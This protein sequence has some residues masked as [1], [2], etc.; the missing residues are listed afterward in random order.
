MSLV[1]AK[2][3]KFCSRIYLLMVDW[4]KMNSVLLVES[5][6]ESRMRPTGLDTRGTLLYKRFGF[7]W[8]F[9]LRR[10][11]QVAMKGDEAASGFQIAG[12]TG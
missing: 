1:F 2:L 11:A 3:D 12:Q 5:I 7:G 9:T 6:L 4:L 8:R 10:S